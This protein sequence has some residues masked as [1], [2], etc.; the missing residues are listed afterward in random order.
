MSNTNEKISASREK[1][2]KLKQQQRAEE[3]YKRE[4]QK[5][6]DSRR[7]Y[8]VGELVVKYFPELSRFEPGT[9]AGN[10]SEFA[11]LENFLSILA[12]QTE[13]M[14]KFKEEAT[15]ISEDNR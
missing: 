1:L 5:K 10:I 11:P 4:Q 3:K 6:K 2:A 13:L 14:M 15:R 8:I 12:G 7:H 9:K